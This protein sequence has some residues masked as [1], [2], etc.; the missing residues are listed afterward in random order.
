M[1]GLRERKA[2]DLKLRIVELLT[3]ALDHRTFDEIS[4]EELCDA[5]M[6]SR[7]TFFRYFPTKDALL[8]YHHSVWI[9]GLKADCLLRRIEGLAALR[10]LF[11]EFGRSFNRHTNLFAYFFTLNEHVSRGGVR[12]E[13]T[14]AERLAL[15]PDGSTLGLAITPSLRE[16]LDRHV[17]VARAAGEIRTD[18]PAGTESLL[19]GALVNGSGL[20]GMRIDPARPGDAFELTF[21]SLLDLLKP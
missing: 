11:T 12:P 20:L 18:V 5:A 21:T 9:Y 17:E 14:A 6:I 10:H 8:A 2:A 4:V 15:H 13:L 3:E 19:F 7:V 16:F 1:P